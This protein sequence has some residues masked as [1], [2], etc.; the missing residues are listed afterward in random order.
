MEKN[1]FIHQTGS[2]PPQEI[3]KELQRRGGVL[4][5]WCQYSGCANN[6]YYYIDNDGKITFTMTNKHLGNH[7]EIYD[8]SGKFFFTTEKQN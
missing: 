5:K 1:V 2:I 3:I 7:Q 6:A 8:V 4:D